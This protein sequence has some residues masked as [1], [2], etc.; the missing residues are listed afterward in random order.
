MNGRKQH[1]LNK[2][3]IVHYGRITNA[4]M[5]IIT[6]LGGE[7]LYILVEMC[8]Q[9]FFFNKTAVVVSQRGQR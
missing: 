5:L 2:P 4:V 1:T 8:K 9:I 7:H 6:L 3:Q